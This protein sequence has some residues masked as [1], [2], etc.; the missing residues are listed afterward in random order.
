[1][2]EVKSFSPDIKVLCR[3]LGGSQLYGLATPESDKDERG[4]IMSTRAKFILGT[5]R[6][7]ESRNQDSAIQ[8]DVVYKELGHWVRLLN[9][10]NT[11]AFEMLF[12]PRSVFT[13]YEN[14][15]DLFRQNPFAFMDSKK[16]FNCLRGYA[17][18]EFR[19]A[20]GERVGVLGSKRKQALDKYGYS[21]RNASHLVRLLNTGITFFKEGRYVVNCADFPKEVYEKILNIK[22]KPT[23]YSVE[24]LAI[25][26]A[27]LE[28]QI[29][30]AYESRKKSYHF[31][32]KEAN[33][34]LL[35]AYFPHLQMEFKKNSLDGLGSV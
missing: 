2:E 32:E 11:E 10:G 17:Q 20:K 8:L 7:D 23:E 1:M 26:Y 15:F 4:L 28:K 27:D 9:A 33:K 12:A 24:Q 35:S 13:V 31:N 21:H 29:V 6:F 22:T 30:E 19:L 34:I 5:G 25:D 3:F 18:S 16:L 14:E